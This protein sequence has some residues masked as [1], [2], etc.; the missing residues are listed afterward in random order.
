ML[1]CRFFLGHDPGLANFGGCFICP[2]V[3]TKSLCEKPLKLSFLR[4][5]V[6]LYS[7]FSQKSLI[8]AKK[9][10]FQTHNWEFSNKN[11]KPPGGYSHFDMCITVFISVH[12]RISIPV[13]ISVHTRISSIL[14][15]LASLPCV[16]NYFRTLLLACIEK[17]CRWFCLC[18][19]KI[20]IYPSRP[21]VQIFRSL[22]RLMRG[23]GGGDVMMMLM[24]S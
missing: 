1:R 22:T 6:K 17:N 11:S 13:F 5:N 3:L 20:F 19:W 9:E 8:K 4:K 14:E 7:E 16:Q 12:T 23:C 15:G 18:H 2:P 21:R 10:D 24:M